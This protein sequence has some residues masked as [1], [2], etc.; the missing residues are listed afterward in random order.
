[1]LNKKLFSK[2][3]CLILLLC[4]SISKGQQLIPKN[5]AEITASSI[6][7]H[8]IWL[9]IGPIRNDVTEKMFDTGVKWCRLGVPWGYV[10]HDSI[11]YYDFTS[12]DTII[13][14]LVDHS[15]TPY[16]ILSDP[17]VLY[18]PNG[19]PPIPDSAVYFAA[20]LAYVDTVV[21]RYRDTVNYWEIW[22][23]PNLDETWLPAANPVQYSALVCSTAK[24]IRAIDSDA[25]I[26]LGGTALIDIR[27]IK[28]CLENG[29][30][31][32]IDKIGIHP[33][34]TLPEAPQSLLTWTPNSQFVS[35]YGSYEEE[36]KALKDTIA[37]FSDTLD[38]WDTEGC[39]LSDS[40]YPDPLSPD[41][42]NPQHSS[43][44]T[45]AKYLARR[46]IISLKQGIELTTWTVDWDM[47]SITN[48]MGRA[49]WVDDYSERTD[50]EFGEAPFCGIVYTPQDVYTF[51]SEGEDYTEIFPLMET[52]YDP[53]ASGDS[54]IWTPNGMG[55]SGYAYYDFDLIES[56]WY[57]LWS[58]SVGNGDSISV[59][60]AALDTMWFSVGNWYSTGEYRW[61][62]AS[63]KFLRF[64]QLE[65]DSHRLYI[66]T[67]WDGSRFDIWNLV[68]VDTNC[69]RKD[70]YYALQ[71]ICSVFDEAVQSTQNFS[72]YFENI[73]ADTSHFNRLAYANF[74]DTVVG[75]RFVAYWFGIEAEDIYTDKLLRLMV[76]DTTVSSAVLIDF[77]SGSVNNIDFY[78]SETLTVFDSLPVADFPYCVALNW[79]TGIY[80]NAKFKVGSAS[81]RAKLEIYPNPFSKLTHI[82]FQAPNSKSQV[83]LSIY[84]AAGRLVK[85]FSRFTLDA[86][87][88]TLLSW[89]GRNDKG[90]LVPSGVYFVQLKAGDELSPACQSKAAG[91]YIKKL[92]LIK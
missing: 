70:S 45:Q 28:S 11:G 81:C 38:I 60:V 34:R 61:T 85:D 9:D 35:P 6:G 21:K 83:T 78:V 19:Y 1:M 25:V 47:H 44:E 16:L 52:I 87:R 29:V 7:M 15:I 33:Y 30:D 27:F 82:K 48:N 58:R 71:N 2:L 41:P 8:T 56:K 80:E 46:Y 90:E 63:G 14:Q 84:D 43:Q 55:D 31:Q 77:V 91:R 18:N 17:N 79:S 26:C 68:K 64:F 40:I 53:F 74:E 50:Y 20:W 67:Y 88:P 22:N 42:L 76:N 3:G 59:F 13:N 39:F 36:I 51:T 92:V 66:I 75:A 32:Y 24:V 5:S 37:L 69:I 57:N 23:E 54:C 73:N 89:D 10:E 4:T 65:P 12:I 86:L 49:D 62:P 72:S